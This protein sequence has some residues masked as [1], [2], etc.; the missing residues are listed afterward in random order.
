MPSRKIPN[1]ST[2]ASCC[3]QATKVSESPRSSRNERAFLAKPLVLSSIQ[4]NSLRNS[5][6]S[7][8]VTKL[9]SSTSLSRSS[10]TTGH[11]VKKTSVPTRVGQPLTLAPLAREEQI[12]SSKRSSQKTSSTNPLLRSPKSDTSVSDLFPG[13]CARQ[14]PMY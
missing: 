8:N 13:P 6:R 12:K 11:Q 2:V 4:L 9:N 1:Q 5:K 14:N 7:S 10:T 3:G